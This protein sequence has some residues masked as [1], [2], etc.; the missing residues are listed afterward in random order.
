MSAFAK[1]KF[2]DYID[3]DSVVLEREPMERVVADGQISAYMH[4]GFF[5]GMDSLRDKNILEELWHSGNAPWK[6]W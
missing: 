4:T 2:L 1:P 3:G 5:Q 6:T